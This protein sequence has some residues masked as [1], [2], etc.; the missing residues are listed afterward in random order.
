MAE[1]LTLEDFGIQTPQN[2]GEQGLT[3][4]DFSSAYPVASAVSRVVTPIAQATEAPVIRFLQHLSRPQEAL[5][6]G[7]QAAFERRYSDILPQM[8]AGFQLTGGDTA[9]WG[10]SIFHP[11]SPLV[12]YDPLH[13]MLKSLPSGEL[14]GIE[15]DPDEMYRALKVGIGEV[16]L[17]PLMFVDILAKL[18]GVS[19]AVA[20]V[21]DF[22]A[23]T[24]VGRALGLNPS[25]ANFGELNRTASRVQPEAQY[26]RHKMAEKVGAAQ[27]QAIADIGEEAIKSDEFWTG[28]EKPISAERRQF[29]PQVQALEPIRAL[30]RKF[31]DEINKYRRAFG[32]EERGVIE[33]TPRY[34]RHPRNLDLPES[35][36][37]GGMRG[38]AA[39]GAQE[40][41]T[42]RSRT[43]FKWV[44]NG[45][46]VARGKVSSNWVPTVGPD[47]V[48]RVIKVSTIDQARD[49]SRIVPRN[50]RNRVIEVAD[51]AGN[52]V[53][54]HL[55]SGKQV[56]KEQLTKPEAQA[57]VGEKRIFKSNPYA[58]H[59]EDLSNKISEFTWWRFADDGVADGWLRPIST[60]KSGIEIIPDGWERLDI[61]GMR[62]YAAPKSAVGRIERVAKTMFNPESFFDSLEEGARVVS[63]SKLGQLA[64]AWRHKWA[65]WQLGAFPRFHAGNEVSNDFLLYTAG[66][67]AHQIPRYKAKAILV[68]RPQS[69]PKMAAELAARWT[70]IEVGGTW[71]PEQFSQ[72]LEK[73]GAFTSWSKAEQQSKLLGYR[74]TP[75]MMDLA[76]EQLSRLTGPLGQKVANALGY[77]TEGLRK[78]GEAGDYLTEFGFRNIGEPIENNGRLAAALWWLDKNVRGRATVKDLHEAAYFAQRALFDYSDLSSFERNVL[79]TIM[80]YWAFH[81]NMVR[82]LLKDLITQPH[83]L[84]RME[85]VGEYVFSTPTEEELRDAPDYLR[86]NAPV[87]G[88]G[89][90]HFGRGEEGPRTALVGR[91]NPYTIADQLLGGG[92]KNMGQYGWNLLIPFL[93]AGP[94]MGWNYQVH[95]GQ[96]I[97][98][99]VATMPPSVSDRSQLEL[100]MLGPLLGT[101]TESRQ[102]MLGANLPNYWQYF[103]GLLPT[104]SFTRQLDQLVEAAGDLTGNEFLRDQGQASYPWWQHGLRQ[105]GVNLYEPKYEM[106]RHFG[107]QKEQD[108]IREIKAQ[109][110][111]AYRKGDMNKA[112]QL[113]NQLRKWVPV[114]A[115]KRAAQQRQGQLNSTTP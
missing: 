38:E 100:G 101:P 98:R 19:R 59:A 90:I 79:K 80:P 18:P 4:E 52:K 46:E 22:A 97:D 29:M 102:E 67:P 31:L 47:K 82:R 24:K 96:P 53:Y 76:E 89:P 68:Q 114:M 95:S 15:L 93:K 106:Y 1:R 104:A 9:T 48:P 26:W 45:E 74:Q 64:S 17:D 77:G 35:I 34:E 14:G 86:Q 56:L 66:V 61:P 115:Q 58:A 88:V 105:L 72:F 84:G 55:G 49:V 63:R 30:S 44:D 36:R 108:F 2:P 3:L 109:M 11:E 62:G 13:M 54:Y 10:E 25:E 39:R 33:D 111:R 57:L 113:R 69:A 81:R 78:I 73:S 91:F 99:T 21:S 85:R 107:R 65:S 110:R 12:K 8:K 60:D 83:R 16:F 75:G 42:G 94:E 50:A 5:Q 28:L 71:T 7:A 41:Q 112:E 92:L 37:R 51:E 103:M 6:R 40:A 43:L 32:M 23:S 20:P 70:P 87:T 27:E